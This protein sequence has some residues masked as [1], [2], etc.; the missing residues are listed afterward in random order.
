MANNNAIG[1]KTTFW[2]LVKEKI[3]IPTLQR[4]YI[5]GAGT[6]KTN[7]VLEN[8]LETFLRAVETGEEETLDFIYG[9]ES[10]AKEFMPLDG[11]QRLTTLYLLHYYAALIAKDFPGK[12]EN[13]ILERL[14]RF[15]YATRNCTIAFCNNLLI[16]KFNDLKVV[17]S[18][19]DA[20]DKN[21]F[22]SYLKDLDDFR[23]AFYT[24]PSVMSMLVVLDRIHLKFNGRDN[25]LECLMANDC[26]I[27]FYQL[28]FGVFDLSDDLY[29]KMNSRGKP[30]TSFEIVKAKMHKHIKKQKKGK[31]DRIAIKFD[32]TWMQYIWEILGR[33]Q[34]LKT[35]DTAYMWL[36]KN[37]FRCFDFI[38]G[39]A[40]QRFEKLDE[41]CLLANST[42][43]CRVNALENVF[44]VFSANVGNIPNAIKNDY[45]GFIKEAVKG[46]IPNTRMLLLYAIYLGLYYKPAND[47]FYFRYRHVR[48]LVNNS[49][50]YIRDEFMSL[51]IVDVT[52]VMKGEI[53][54]I[55][56]P[57]K[58]NV[59]S[60]KEEQEK[61]QHREVWKLFFDYEDI[62]E[63]N[64]T[65]C[66]FAIGLNSTDTLTL[67]D[68]AFVSALLTRV[69]KAAHL[70]ETKDLQEHDCRSALLSIGNYAMAKKDEPSYRYF[71]VI[72][73][74]WQNFTGYHI[75]DERHYIMDVIDKIDVNV[76]VRGLVGNTS[77]TPA[78]NWRYYAI[79]YA[80]EITVAYRSPDYGYMYFHGI[81]D[82]NPYDENKSYLD[83]V[84]LQSKYYSDKNVAW[85]MMHRILEQKYGDQYN[86]Y[87]DNHG[88]SCIFLSKISA[89]ALLDMQTD[90]WHLIG[91]PTTDLAA[92]G[93]TYSIIKQ[94][95]DEVINEKGEVVQ[96]LQLCDCR[97]NHEKGK[98]YVEEGENILEN[99]SKVYPSLKK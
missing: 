62:S 76:D 57:N 48:N 21:V 32:T 87:L 39:Y 45:E 89:D 43:A 50:D 16:G 97:I 38:S 52:H 3:T 10:N 98:D 7:E 41:G 34:E 61:E 36:L 19:A 35:V 2:K 73:G 70:F 47:E 68:P 8:M 26:P 90:G 20:D 6:E 81:D 82:K 55:E 83:V 99:L 88:E 27:N 79:K 58:M 44:D 28:D 77:G 46:Y 65:I 25:L 14:S 69:K 31:A 15:S 53:S 9:S 60:W 12:D 11:Q 22:S 67:G 75:Y 54:C 30:L 17:V 71:G 37:I 59:N 63:I 96:Q 42:S 56:E 40:K 78:E 64:G 93:L 66:A 80:K 1:G 92:A 51:L 33:T 4:D 5:Y 94:P 24:D 85:K 84:I 13:E 49:S 23:G 72:K 91:I 86:M 74:S 95:I 18:N 29:N